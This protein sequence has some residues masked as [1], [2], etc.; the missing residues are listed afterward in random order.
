MCNHLS[1]FWVVFFWC[2]YCLKN[3]KVAAFK[4]SVK[5]YT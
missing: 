5:R 4:I 3:I 2:K 1:L